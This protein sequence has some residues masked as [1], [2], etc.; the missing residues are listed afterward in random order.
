MQA[1]SAF[2]ALM[3]ADGKPEVQFKSLKINGRGVPATAAAHATRSI[4]LRILPF[5]QIV[6][7]LGDPHLATNVFDSRSRFHL[8]QNCH[9]L[10]FRVT[11]LRH[12]PRLLVRTPPQLTSNLCCVSF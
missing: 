6:R 10:L 1:P 4:P 3:D 2:T 7:G 5:P 11:T 9:D 12:R 8:P